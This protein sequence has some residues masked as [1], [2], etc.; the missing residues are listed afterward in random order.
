MKES[1]SGRKYRCIVTS[2]D[3][4]LVSEEA[5]IEIPQPDL[6]IQ[7]HPSD[8]E[9]MEGEKVNLHVEANRSD[10]AYQW[11]YSKNGTTWTNCT[12]KGY[13]TDTFS[14]LMKASLAGRY[15]RCTVTAGTTTVI[16]DAAYISMK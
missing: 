15:Y 8:V 3:D 2:G 5:L 4:S 10:A 14:F 16:S 11:Q 1:L 7:M 12:S 6:A 9:V 13:N